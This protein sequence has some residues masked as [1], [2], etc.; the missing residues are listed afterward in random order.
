MKLRIFLLAIAAVGSV[1]CFSTPAQSYAI[2]NAR[3]VTVSGQTIESGTV[4]VRDGLIEAVGANVQAPADAKVYD[5][6]GLTVYPGIIDSLTNLGVPVPTRPTGG[7][8]GFQM[9]AAA[10]APSTSNSNY[11]AGL[12][13]EDSTLTDLRAGDAQFEASRNAGFTT[14][15]TTGR[16]GIFNGRSALINL[17]GPTISAITVK[18][19]VALHITFTTIP[20]T[21]PGSLLG[22]F[23]ALRQMLND[24]RRKKEIDRLY[25]ADPKGIRR[26][27]ADRSLE[28]LIPVL[29]GRVPVI[30]HANQENEIV[31]A[32]NLAKE[33]GLKAI[34]G[35]GQEADK[36]A[37]RLKTEGVPVLL[38][39]NFPKRTAAAARDAD[40][41]TLET[42]RFRAAVPK[43]AGKLASAGVKFAFQSG[44]ATSVAD[45]FTNAGRSAENGI[46]KDAAIR[47]MTLTPAEIFGV[48]DRMGSIEAGKIANL[49]VVRGDLLAPQ[50]TITHVFVD[51][52]PFEP[53][54]PA[55]PAGP[56]GRG[57]PGAP[58]SPGVQ[59]T[60]PAPA[61]PAAG[62]PA[63]ATNLAG[64][65]AVMIQAPGQ[66]IAGT[67]VLAQQGPMLTGSLNTELGNVSLTDARVSGNG[68]SAS[69]TAVVGGESVPFTMRVTVT[70]NSLSGTVE[71]AQGNMPITGT[72]NP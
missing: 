19:P 69:G 50:H 34:I 61:P 35:G 52:V 66:T 44:G 68:F 32:L 49:T 28:A 30:F 62:D 33:Y 59:G 24:A 67:L 1:F 41:E 10:T 45:F 63:S 11:P 36:F 22:T 4:V 43:V 39:M 54:A 7:Q 42:L 16:T 57:R 29:D 58:G 5:G 14:A 27:E 25:A 12:R 72:K 3:I 65:Y 70:G 26:P 38:S 13:P 9:A 18:D 23:S 17:A 56:G 8:G 48:D 2:R 21:Y 31:R 46:S 64:T 15:L 37:S 6:S 60:Q 20:G 40:P 53:K 51:G 47:A 55:A 71:S